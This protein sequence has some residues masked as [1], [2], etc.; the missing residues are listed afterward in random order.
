MSLHIARLRAFH[1]PFI[2]KPHR[3][4]VICR[5]ATL[6]GFVKVERGYSVEFKCLNCTGTQLKRTLTVD[7]LRPLFRR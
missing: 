6:S 1:G 4:C 5:K 3:V 7:D 2:D